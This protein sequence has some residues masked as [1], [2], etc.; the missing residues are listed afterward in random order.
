MRAAV[1]W[2]VVGVVL[3]GAGVGA[4]EPAP[5]AADREAMERTLA[6]MRDLGNVWMSWLGEGLL[7]ED[8]G[9]PEWLETPPGVVPP[10]IDLSGLPDP[11]DREAVDEWAAEM[12]AEAEAKK[13]WEEGRAHRVEWSGYYDLE[14]LP[15]RFTAAELAA[16]LRELLP[17]EEVDGLA[18]EDGWGRPFEL[19]FSGWLLAPRVMAIRSS[20]RDGEASGTQY[21]IGPVPPDPDRD[22]VWADGFFLRWP[23]GVGLRD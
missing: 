7:A 2:T 23:D 9:R 17:A 8:F 4:Q 1:V 5:A 20:G 22:I 21:R 3:G 10:R 16:L 6:A 19:F 12:L 13:A 11:E 15:V 14:R 18:W